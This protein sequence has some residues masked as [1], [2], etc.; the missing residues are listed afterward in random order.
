MNQVMSNVE[1]EWPSPCP[2]S[3]FVFRLNCTF[4]LYRFP[5]TV[6]RIGFHTL[7]GLTMRLRHTLMLLA[8]GL[9]TTASGQEAV[10]TIA[11]SAMVVEVPHNFAKDVGLGEGEHWVLSARETKLLT[12]TINREKTAVKRSE[13]S[14]R[15]S[16]KA[17]A[18]FSGG[19]RDRY[20][21]AITPRISAAGDNFTLTI[22]SKNTHARSDNGTDTQSVIVTQSVPV[23]S[24]VVVR[25]AVWKSETETRELLFVVTP[26]MPSPTGK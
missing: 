4:G 16:D 14:L 1:P 18:F 2:R 7:R 3:T 23:G 25:T 13:P 6:R 20:E 22:E 17:I 10:P 11:V 19:S 21:A 24:A 15:V 8:F 12:A 9:T 26:S 5:H